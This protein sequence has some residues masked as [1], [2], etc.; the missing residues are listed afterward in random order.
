MRPAYLSAVWGSTRKLRAP[1]LVLTVLVKGHRVD[2]VQYA[3]ARSMKLLWRMLTECAD[4]L[5]DFHIVWLACEN[6]AAREPGPIGVLKQVMHNMSWTWV[7]PDLIHRP[8]KP[9]LS[10]T[11][12]PSGWWHHQIREGL[13]GSEWSKAAA[14]RNYCGGLDSVGGVHKEVTL[15]M[16]NSAKSSPVD[17][18]LVAQY[19]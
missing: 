19:S 7:T 12:E 2:P 8:E 4:V 5:A 18:G 14:R 10:I 3:A 1:E 13:R 6:G 16:L 11:R 9:T 15:N 17:K